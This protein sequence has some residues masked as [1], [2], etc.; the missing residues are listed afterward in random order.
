MNSN[1]ATDLPNGLVC[2]TQESLLV[3]ID[4]V[5]PVLVLLALLLLITVLAKIKGPDKRSN[6]WI[7]RVGMAWRGR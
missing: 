3:R 6:R 2:Y 1:G 5:P 4:L 7:A